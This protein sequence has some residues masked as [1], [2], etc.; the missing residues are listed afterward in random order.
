MMYETALAEMW[1][2]WR[3]GT[4]YVGKDDIVRWSET[5]GLSASKVFHRLAV[6]LS[7]D[8]FVGFLGWDFTNGAANELNGTMLQFT[9]ETDF[10]WPDAFFE[11]Y[12][13]FDHSEMEGPRDRE[14]IREFL[15]K[16]R[17]LTR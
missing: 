17:T 8:F 15:Q 6:E 11:F 3:K 13:A 14:L 12:C 16:H 2:R 10:V 9:S 1:A 7:S 4:F 5:S